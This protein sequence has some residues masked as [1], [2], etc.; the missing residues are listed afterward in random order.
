MCI[1]YPHVYRTDT[2]SNVSV[3]GSQ[4][5]SQTVWQPAG[6]A[7]AP[8]TSIYSMCVN[9]RRVLSRTLSLQRKF[10]THLSSH[11]LPE[12]LIPYRCR[13]RSEPARIIISS[14]CRGSAVDRDTHS[15]TQPGTDTRGIASPMHG[16]KCLFTVSFPW[17]IHLLCISSNAPHSLPTVCVSCNI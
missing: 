5:G 1:L 3:A 14:Y 7:D 16:L 8:Q 15:A 13:T 4:P 9:K 12:L 2:H 10:R 11:H 6:V 17:I